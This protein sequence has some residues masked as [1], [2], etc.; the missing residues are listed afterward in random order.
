MGLRPLGREVAPQQDGKKTCQTEPK[1]DF[2]ARALHVC[3]SRGPRRVAAMLRRPSL[4]LPAIVQRADSLRKVAV[5]V[6]LAAHHKL[7][8]AEKLH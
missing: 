6:N 4:G 1:T 2:S 7:V 3:V 8:V 5:A